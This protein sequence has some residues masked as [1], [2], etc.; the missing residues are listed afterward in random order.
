MDWGLQFDV[1]PPFLFLYYVEV[2]KEN[3]AVVYNESVSARQLIIS[4]LD[5]CDRYLATVIARC[6]YTS[7]VYDISAW[8]IGG[9]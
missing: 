2:R 6:Q 4:S 7:E 3:G 1:Q 8:F 9:E 5:P